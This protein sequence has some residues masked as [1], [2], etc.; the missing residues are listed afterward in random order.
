MGNPVGEYGGLD[1]N[2]R[3]EIEVKPDDVMGNPTVIHTIPS[4]E[5]KQEGVKNILTKN[6]YKAPPFRT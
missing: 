2:K 5:D 3:I 1:I 6:F 4:I